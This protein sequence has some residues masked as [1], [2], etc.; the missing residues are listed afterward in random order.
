MSLLTPHR[1]DSGTTPVSP[2]EERFLIPS[3]STLAELNLLERENILE[4]RRWLFS[5]RRKFTPTELLDH[6]L[7]RELHRRM[8]RHIWRWAGKLRDCELNLGVPPVEVGTRL[9]S[10]LEDARAWISYD[11]FPAD[12]LCVR[13]H[14]GLVAIHPWRNGNGRHARLVAD[15]LAVALGR[16]PFTWGGGIELEAKNDTRTHYLTALRQADQG[17]FAALVAFARS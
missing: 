12:E 17:D 5:P 6:L 4:A 16:V 3:V 1:D 9:V 15:R 2:D 8:F 10:L 11:T 14:H 13:L 7:V